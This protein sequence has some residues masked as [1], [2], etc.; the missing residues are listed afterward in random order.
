[1]N[2]PGRRPTSEVQLPIPFQWVEVNKQ[3]INQNSLMK[4]IPEK[5]ESSHHSYRRCQD[6]EMFPDKQHLDADSFKRQDNYVYPA[7]KKFTSDPSFNKHSNTELKSPY[8]MS[9]KKCFH[10]R[11]DYV[12]KNGRDGSHPDSYMSPLNFSTTSHSSLESLSHYSTQRS[13]VRQCSCSGDSDQFSGKEIRKSKRSVYSVANQTEFLK[14]PLEEKFLFRETILLGC[15]EIGKWARKIP[16][17]S[18]ISEMGD[19]IREKTTQSRAQNICS[20]LGLEVED[21]VIVSGYLKVFLKIADSW[22]EARNCFGLTDN[23]MKKACQLNNPEISQNYLEWQ[24]ASRRLLGNIIHGVG[25]V[26][27]PKDASEADAHKMDCRLSRSTSNLQK[28][29][30]QRFS[31]RPFLQ[32]QKWTISDT[33][34]TTSQSSS[35]L[36]PPKYSQNVESSESH[37]ITISDLPQH[38]IIPLS[39]IEPPCLRKQDNRCPPVDFSAWFAGRS[40]DGSVKD[41]QLSNKQKSAKSGV[42]KS[43]SVTVVYAAD[44]SQDSSDDIQ[45]K[46][47]MKPGSYNVP[48]KKLTNAKKRNN[49]QKAKEACCGDTDIP[50]GYVIPFVNA[51][52][53]VPPPS[54][55]LQNPNIKIVKNEN[56]LEFAFK[57]D[58][59]RKIAVKDDDKELCSEEFKDNS[60]DRDMIHKDG[61]LKQSKVPSKTMKTDEWILT[62]LMN[63]RALRKSDENE[64]IQGQEKFEGNDASQASQASSDKSSHGLEENVTNRSQ[65]SIT[66][67]SL[68]K[69]SKT[70]SKMWLNSK[71]RRM[72]SQ[73]TSVRIEE[74]VSALWNCDMPD[75]LKQA[76]KLSQVS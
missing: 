53:F 36:N 66:S 70:N 27:T 76:V 71:R 43:Q 64:K 10:N 21:Q 49:V 24:L 40:A 72:L 6:Y 32:R 4:P 28:Y 39:Q 63:S 67:R 58:E 38:K 18:E 3:K 25:S 2:I 54:R 50:R 11:E 51:G 46:I 17:V 69:I 44:G 56:L 65:S 33:A 15:D 13:R 9:K 48:K 7:N 62:T 23:C 1:M 30:N 19:Y 61:N 45:Q 59:G 55:G 57:S 42:Q 14:S 16:M 12:K 60:Q 47:Y 26:L 74:V 20:A 31:K 34:S 52:P 37:P 8:K 73:P 5:I 41:S 22:L 68:G 35:I 29:C 75:Y